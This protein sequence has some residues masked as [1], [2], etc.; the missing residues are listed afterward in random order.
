MGMCRNGQARKLPVLILGGMLSV[1]CYS[2]TSAEPT[3]GEAG[4][5][6]GSVD[7][8]SSDSGDG[9]DDGND[10]ADGGIPSCDA[11]LIPDEVA[12]RRLT[13]A[14]YA[15]TVRDLL[16]WAVADDAETIYASLAPDI[17]QIPDDARYP[18]GGQ[19]LGGF[20]RLD[21]SV[22]QQHVDAGYRVGRRLGTAVTET[23]QRL[24]ALAGECAVDSDAGNDDACIDAFIRGFGERA[25]RRPLEADEVATYRAVFDGEGTTTG[26]EAEA[27]VD[28]IAAMM[29]A[30]QFMYMVEHGDAEVADK[31]N[32]YAL[33]G[34]DL[35]SRLSYHFW[36]TSP[37][38]ELRGAAADG[39]LVDEDVY[40]AQVDR[41][42]ADPRARE[43]VGSFYRE[44]L[45]LDDV[46]PVGGLIGTPAYDTFLRDTPIDEQTHANML[47]EVID[48]VTYY[49][50]D[51]DGSLADLLLSDR[52]FARTADLAAIY[53]VEPWD[54]GEPPTLPHAERAGILGRAALLS[55]RSTVTRPIRK[56]VYIRMAVL[57]GELPPPPP[58]AE[59]SVPEFDGEMTT[60]EIVAALTEQPGSSCAG[61]H[62][63]II[64]PLGYVSENFDA[65]G[66]FRTEQAI[67]DQ[68][69]N[70]VATRPVDTEVIPGVGEEAGTSVQDL[71]ELAE[72]IVDGEAVRACFARH[73]VRF[74]FGRSEDLER[75]ACMLG[76]LY[77]RLDDEAP[78]AEVMRTLA[79]RP[80]FRQ[81]SFE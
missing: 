79:L 45:W 57:C 43:A 27:F 12:L 81:R 7:D 5:G 24:A 34:W 6:S 39:T 75:D 51:T 77:Q 52:S 32:V 38:D 70:V 69:G 61:C 29:I 63:S 28:V 2:G 1:G 22:Q 40:A 15:N 55:N 68:D 66:R 23:P 47:Q 37:D 11:S 71:R 54:G 14:Q 26:T 36:Q 58:D 10:G 73:Y 4:D 9:D 31:P 60:R 80:E 46:A 56:G 53:D 64:N 50:F 42:F 59:M 25:L 33:N 13:K 78:L 17:S 16:Q 8:G 62:A 20:R 19:H 3:G 67:Y 74:T 18:G 21:Q 48:M 72:A 30:P 76:D 41:L 49:T 35:A 65:L 44:W